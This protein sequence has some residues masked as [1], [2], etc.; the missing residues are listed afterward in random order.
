[1]SRVAVVGSGV[2]GLTA[3]YVISR[4]A[5]VT[6]F[7]ADDRLGGHADTH[8]VDGMAI[9]T[10]FIVHNRKTYPTLLRLFDELGVTTQESDMS[11]SVRSDAAHGGRG[12]EW[13]GAMGPGGLFPRGSN[14]ARPRFWR[15]LTE[16][17]RF[18]RRAR[19]LLDGPDDDRTLGQFLDEGA[20]STYFRRHFMAPLVAA[21][22]SCDPA[23][24]MDYPA[25]YL[26]TFL[27]HH[28]M[29]QVFGSPRWRTVTGGSHVY[30]D[31]VAAALREHGGRV[32]VDAKVTSVV[33]TAAGVS[34]TDGNGVVRDFD[35]VVIATH[36]GQALSLLG[37]PTP[38]QSELLSA[39]P[40]SAN[41]AQLHTDT[42]LLPR[43]RAAWASW[44]HLERPDSD[45]VT[46]TYDLT[47]LMRLP[48]RTHYLVTLGA[49]D[50]VDPDTVIATRAYEHPIYTPDSLAA[51]RRL[52]EI[53]SD[54]LAFAGAWH[55][56]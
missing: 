5:T 56:S 18:H 29:L 44:N 52:H 28:G 50:L 36:P 17:P 31:R 54:R 46:V 42:S 22:W 9:D 11:L 15:M 27:A 19:R 39:M 21:V 2:A 51:Q 4:S 41:L 14:L 40:Y 12:L 34:V 25:R 16:I 30:V 13:A 20:F 35:Q 32:L 26:F 6:L 38:L 49:P 55:G 3:A 8:Q 53:D 47:R 33:E 37:E 48:T 24:A 45:G 43:R 7:E 23:I 1:M 10:G